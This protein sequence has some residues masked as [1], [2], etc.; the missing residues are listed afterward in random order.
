MLRRH[1]AFALDP[2]LWAHEELNFTPDPWQESLLRSN[3]RRIILCCARQSGK[4][5]IV[6]L[7]ALHRAI[8]DP[9]SLILLVSPS[10]RQSSELFRIVT[11]FF[12]QLDSPI[13]PEQESALR[14]TL[15][16]RSR[17]VSL[18]GKEQTVRGFSGVDLLV[19]DEAARVQSDLY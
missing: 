2:V 11:T 16:N 8:Y 18:P 14:L 17:L 3:A 5:T 1:L 7:K 6:A 19:I 10:L 12:G 15:E 9:G 4:S 13:G